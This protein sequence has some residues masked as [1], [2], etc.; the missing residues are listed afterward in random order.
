MNIDGKSAV[1]SDEQIQAY[2]FKSVA[3]YE[4]TLVW[5]NASTPDLHEEQRFDRYP[6][7]VVPGPGALVFTS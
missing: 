4:H 7:S 5:I 2:E 3:N 1:Q 6:D